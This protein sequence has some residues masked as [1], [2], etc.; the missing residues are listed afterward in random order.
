MNG[1]TWITEPIKLDFAG[2]G[3]SSAEPDKD[4][5]NY[6]EAKTVGTVGELYQ[7]ES[8]LGKISLSCD[9]TVFS[10][11]ATTYHHDLATF[12]A[13][14]STMIYNENK[15]ATGNNNKN[16]E[17]A[18]NALGYKEIKEVADKVEDKAPYC[19]AYKTVVLDGKKTNI[20]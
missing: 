9:E 7:K 20:L 19:L 11:N 4:L 17:D 13:G 5:S 3:N 8:G 18:L 15:D 14:M 1:N 10:K 6:T 2:T 16:M 12:A